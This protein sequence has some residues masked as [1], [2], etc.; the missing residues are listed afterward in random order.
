VSTYP[1]IRSFNDAGLAKFMAVMEGS[2]PLAQINPADP[3]Y[4]AP[5]PGTTALV[6]A[7]FPNR[8][9]MAQAICHAFGA[10]KPEALQHETGIWTW[11]TWVLREQLFDREAKTGQLKVGEEWVWNPARP[12]QY[13]KAQR[14]K[15]RLPVVI[16]ST[17]GNDADH[18]LHGPVKKPGEL[19]SQL[20]SQQDMLA[21]SFQRLCRKLYFD[22][23]AGKVKR[24]A[25]GAGAGSARRLARIRKQLDITWDMSDLDSAAIAK[26]LPGEFDKFRQSV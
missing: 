3:Q 12:D 23:A 14:H 10:L 17:L 9:A 18:L 11:L 19:I 21:P 2:D 26:L 16:W 13:Q 22:D 5:V 7:D 6:I 25:A 1:E 15:V 24:G 4:S 20:T 8:K